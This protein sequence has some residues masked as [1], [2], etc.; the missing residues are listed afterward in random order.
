ML[1]GILAASRPLSWVNTAVPFALTYLLAQGE[2]TVELV[3]GFILS[4]IHI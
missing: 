2:V 4:L 3:V 1:S